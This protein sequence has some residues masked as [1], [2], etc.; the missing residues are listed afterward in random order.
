MKTLTLLFTLSFVLISC[1]GKKTYKADDFEATGP[2]NEAPFFGKIIPELKFG[3]KPGCLVEI[4]KKTYELPEDGMV[5]LWGPKGEVVIDSLAC[6]RDHQWLPKV[7][8]T[9]KVPLF[10][11]VGGNRVSYFGTVRIHVRDP[12]DIPAGAHGPFKTEYKITDEM[13]E[14]SKLLRDNFPDFDRK[15]IHKS[16]AVP[17][18]LE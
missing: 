5:Y 14:A 4:E 16:L 6:F 12:E 18:T 11:N 1:S 3:K 8:F 15:R 9:E 7:V 10:Q 13:A 17:T 2:G